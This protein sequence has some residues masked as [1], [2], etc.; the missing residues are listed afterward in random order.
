MC[1]IVTQVP[2]WPFSA[3]SVY[4]C[5]ESLWTERPQTSTVWSLLLQ[6]ET[7]AGWGTTLLIKPMARFLGVG[8]PPTFSTH[9][10]Q[11][12]P[13]Y[14]SSLARISSDISLADLKRFISLEILI[15]PL[16]LSCTF[17]QPSEWVAL[18]QCDTGIIMAVCLWKVHLLCVEIMYNFVIVEL[19]CS[20]GGLH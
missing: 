2:L 14:T 5:W 11:I 19:S 8:Q 7:L 6:T 16:V 20:V 10:A 12:R 9:L 17:R 1:I 4:F 3:G 18:N 13:P 15:V